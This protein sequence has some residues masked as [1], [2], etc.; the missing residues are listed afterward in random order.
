MTPQ[1]IQEVAKKMASKTSS[2]PDNLSSKL[3]KDI[4]TLIINPLC[5]LFNLSFQTGYVHPRFKVAKVIPIFKSGDKHLF[6][7]YRPISLLSSIS[8]LLEKIVAKQMQGFLSANSILFQHQYGFR[9]SHNTTH[10]VIQFLNKIHEALNHQVPKYTL[11]I[12]L[13]LKKAFDTVNHSILIEKLEHYGIR[14]IAKDWFSNYLTGRYQYVTIDGVDS[15]KEKITCGVPQGS[16]LGPILFLIYINDLSKVTNFSSFLFADD[17]TFQL[18]SDNIESLYNNSNIELDKVATWCKS[19]KLTINVSKTKYI[20][21]RHKGMHWPNNNLTLKIGNEVI[22][23]VGQ[24]LAEKN[25]KFLGH[26]IDENL[27]WSHHIRY[28]QNKISSGN[29]LL[30]RAKNDL[31]QNIKLMLYN[32]LIRPHLEYGIL[33][34]GGL[35]KSMLKGVIT[36]QKKAIRNVMGKRV[37]AHTAPLFLSLGELTFVDLL[38]YNSAVFMYKYNNNLLPA[39]FENLFTPCNP[40]NRTISYKIVKT[41]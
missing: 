19:N 11:G 16:V 8:K 27:S 24:N 41:I 13:D 34:W 7:N 20:L 18:S 23:R 38:K 4:L 40:P 32:T 36:V 17:T 15:G 2:G 9:K 28:V 35:A 25:F 33:A 29:Y 3:L 6:T 31:P 39:S 14:G 1:I 37:N 21:F 10:A 26:L 12:F 22:E 5:H 30:A